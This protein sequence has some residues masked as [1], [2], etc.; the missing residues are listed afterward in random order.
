I[1]DMLENAAAFGLLSNF[2][3]M[4]TDSRSFLSLARHDYF[5]RILC[6]FV[7]DKAEAGEFPDDVGSLS[8]LVG[9]LCYGNAKSLLCE[10]GD[11]IF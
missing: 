11:G 8:R 7:A 5:R 9:D 6:N 3:G 10:K 2:V 4:T 1:T